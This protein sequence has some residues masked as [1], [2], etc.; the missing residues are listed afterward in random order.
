MK[1]VTIAASR[2]RF[3]IYN[4]RIRN[5]SASDP[6]TSSVVGSMHHLVMVCGRILKEAIELGKW[7][8]AT[9]RVA[10]E[11]PKVSHNEGVGEGSFGVHQPT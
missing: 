6:I 9:G 4:F 11:E 8:L 10:T 1:L 5:T 3:E 2:L 7:G